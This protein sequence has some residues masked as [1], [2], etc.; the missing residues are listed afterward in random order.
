MQHLRC[1]VLMCGITHLCHRLLRYLLCTFAA[2]DKHLHGVIRVCRILGAFLMQRSQ[3]LD[4]MTDEDLLQSGSQC[5]P[6]DH[7]PLPDAPLSYYRY[8]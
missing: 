1:V 4:H 7:E 5:R 8:M 6:Y 3:V 2:S